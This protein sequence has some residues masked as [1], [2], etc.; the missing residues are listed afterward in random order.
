MIFGNFTYVY[1]NY[2]LAKKLCENLSSKFLYFDRESVK[3]SLSEEFYEG[4]PCIAVN[5]RVEMNSSRNYRPF[6]SR[7]CHRAYAH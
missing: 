7:I 2:K 4:R 5:N 3:V 1:L 6:D